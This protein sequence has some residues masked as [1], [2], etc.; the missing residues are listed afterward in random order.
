MFNTESSLFRIVQQYNS[1]VVV[2]WKHGED[3]IV[4]YIGQAL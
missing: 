2:S 4:K 3:V 1:L